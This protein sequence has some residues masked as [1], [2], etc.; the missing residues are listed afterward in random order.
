MDSSPATLNHGEHVLDTLQSTQVAALNRRTVPILGACL[1]LG[2]AT[3]GTFMGPM[4]LRTAGIARVA[5]RSRPRGERPR[6]AL[7]GRVGGAWGGA[8]GRGALPLPAGDR[9]LDAAAARPRL[10]HGGGR[11]G[12]GLPRR[13][14]FDL[15]G[16]DQRRRPRAAA[17]RAASSPSSGS[18]PMPTTTPRETSPQRQHARHG[19][20]LPRRRGE[21]RADPGQPRPSIR[22]R[23]RASTS[24]AP[25][26]STRARRRGSSPHGIDTVDMRQIDE[27]GVSALLAERIEGWR[28]RGRASAR[29][30]RRRLPRPG[31][32]AGHRH[33]GA[34]RRHLPRGASGDGDALRRGLVGSV[35]VV[36]LNPF[37][38]ERGRTRRDRH[39]ARGEPLRPHRARPPAGR[40]AAA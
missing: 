39:R 23:R 7:G 20:L 29:E 14:P 5:R 9:R 19:A 36:E 11:R 33:R 4:A 32:G 16:H 37:L 8:A 1:E 30:L 15:D 22:C 21:P 24:S 38:D 17:S 28:A 12:A 2:A 18:T 40:R 13:R 26:R 6:H 3:R 35:D 31:G 25:A 10:R 27:R 34:G